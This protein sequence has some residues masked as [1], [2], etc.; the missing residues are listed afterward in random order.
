MELRNVH[1]N[2]L[3]I[4]FGSKSK[5]PSDKEIFSFFR[6]R[7]W[8]P[9]MLCAMFREA[10][11][12]C[13]YVKFQSEEIMRTELIKCSTSENFTYDDG[14]VTPVTFSTAKGDFRYVRLFSLPIEV[15]DK[16]VASAL[17]KY[18]KVHQLV[19]EKYGV[20]TG[21][22]ILNGVR[23]AH[24]EMS[25]AVPSQ[26]RVQHFQARVFYEGMQSKCFT[27]GN[28]DH[29]KQNCPKRQTV[30]DRLKQVRSDQASFAGVV[31]DGAGASN[32]IPSTSTE[33]PVLSGQL[34]PQYKPQLVEEQP[35]TNDVKQKLVEEV[36][37]DLPQDTS[38]ASEME[39]AEGDDHGFQLVESRKRALVKKKSEQQPDDSET[40]ATETDAVEGI[41]VP[42]SQ[43]LLEDQVRQT[44]SRSKKSKN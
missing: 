32:V 25:T 37:P 1:A 8:E 31:K 19:R 23:G 12:F 44:R 30:N 13:V 15:E 7:K 9:D 40:S 39:V 38:S 41:T 20:D 34:R 11:E 18:G 6:K 33:F 17:S 24:M 28:P 21:Y 16:H 27:C 43:N 5:M 2:S 3:K 4:H 26:L 42:E 29:V 35:Q 22:P 14:S 10:R 36:I